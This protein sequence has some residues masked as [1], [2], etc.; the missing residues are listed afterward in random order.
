MSEGPALRL[1]LVTG[2]TRAGSTNSAAL[3]AARELVPDSVSTVFYERL[4]ELPAFNPDDDFDPLPPAVAAFRARVAE[5]DAVLF[6]VPEYAGTLPGSFKNL[7]DWT[8]G[9]PEMYGKPA[10]WINVA[11]PGRGEG[12]DATLA[13]VLG[14]I[15]AAVAESAGARVTVPRDALTEDGVIADP[16]VRARLADVLAGQVR[17]LAALVPAS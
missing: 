3:R 14:Y 16:E 10:S 8:V 5:S 13:T 15:H 11:A 4:A 2:S 7:L 1:L 6:C 12:T 17:E 9:G